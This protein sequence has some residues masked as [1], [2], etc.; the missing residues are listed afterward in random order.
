MPCVLKFNDRIIYPPHCQLGLSQLQVSFRTIRIQSYCFLKRR[1]GLVPLA[2]AIQGQASKITDEEYCS[3]L[4]LGGRELG[5]R[6]FRPTHAQQHLSQSDVA[7]RQ[8]VTGFHEIPKN[9]FRFL[10]TPSRQVR[11]SK[12]QMQSV[13]LRTCCKT[14]LN[15]RDRF[16]VAAQ[17]H[18]F[19]RQIEPVL[20]AAR[21]ERGCTVE[22][23]HCSITLAEA[24]V[25]NPGQGPPRDYLVR[26]RWRRRE[27]ADEVLDLISCF[28]ESPGKE[29]RQRQVELSPGS[30]G[31][32]LAAA[33]LSH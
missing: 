31:S 7:R 16:P 6:L 22:G 19:A 10:V 1:D 26:F 21:G 18:Q 4:A 2:G 3:Q 13:G 20:F 24:G 9:S 30:K 28:L 32:A 23:I 8:G 14:L 33:E 11:R 15:R 29:V 12:P 27:G 5:G 25:C 17:F